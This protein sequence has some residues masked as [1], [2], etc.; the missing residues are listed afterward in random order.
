MGTIVKICGLRTVAHALAAVEAGADMLGLIFAPARRQVEPAQAAAIA[1]EVRAFCLQRRS[2]ERIQLVGV[3]VNEQPDRMLAL[4]HECDLDILQLSGDEDVLMAHDL[5]LHYPIIKAVRFRGTREEQDWIAAT[6]HPRLRLLVEAHT[7]GT[8]GGTGILADWKQATALAR[9]HKIML[10]GGLNPLNIAEAIRSVQP[11]GVDV[12]SGVE[13]DGVKD[14]VK[15]RAFV[16]AVHL[17]ESRA[18]ELG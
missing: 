8:Y 7:V 16:D 11:W 14:I 18:G 5:L 4:A 15:I 1:A 10:A 2:S 12:S 17:G 3:F 13:T 6:S 9:H